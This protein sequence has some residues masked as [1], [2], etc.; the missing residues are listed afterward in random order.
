MIRG[1]EKILKQM[2]ERRGFEVLILNPQSGLLIPP[3]LSKPAERKLYEL[4]GHYSFRLFARDL[5]KHRADIEISHLTNY[6]DEELA[7]DYLEDLM[8]FGMLKK[9]RGKLQLSS[10]EV[11]SFGET[12]EWYVAQMFLRELYSP[13]V[14]GVKL[15]G[16]TNGGDF[17]VLAG[18]EGKIIYVETKSAP[19]RGIDNSNMDAFFSRLNALSPGAV[20][21]LDDTTLRMRDKLV[22]MCEERIGRSLTKL[23]GETYYLDQHFYLTNS[24]PSLV[25]NIKRCVAH[26]LRREPL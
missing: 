19:P 14:W 11:I 25:D 7:R 4:L 5:I 23:H 9:V 12:L 22:P 18:V 24:R 2:I 20:I 15:K 1:S 13:A 26:F 21:L 17:D 6:C 3:K 8:R 16:L 10:K